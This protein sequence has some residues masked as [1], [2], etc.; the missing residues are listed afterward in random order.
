MDYINL[1]IFSFKAFV[2][3]SCLYFSA[4]V[5][6]LLLLYLSKE[7]TKFYILLYSSRINSLCFYIDFSIIDNPLSLWPF[8]M[9]CL[10]KFLKSKTSHFNFSFPWDC[11]RISLKH[12]KNKSFTKSEFPF[13]FDFYWEI[14]NITVSNWTKCCPFC[15][16]LI[17]AL[18]RSSSAGKLFLNKTVVRYFTTDF[19]SEDESPPDIYI[20]LIIFYKLSEVI[21][22][23][24]I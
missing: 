2:C 5:L 14:T 6:V 16:L 21:W 7:F 15:N 9:R 8:S 19:L 4:F 12:F 13:P 23:F 1:R 10:P 22:D 20:L 17:E 24:A 3:N 18:E 11:G